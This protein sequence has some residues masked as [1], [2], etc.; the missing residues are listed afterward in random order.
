MALVSSRLNLIGFIIVSL[1]GSE[2]QRVDRRGRG[3]FA[4]WR[5]P[6]A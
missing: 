4:P 5:H 3:Q 2:L 6:Q 1:L